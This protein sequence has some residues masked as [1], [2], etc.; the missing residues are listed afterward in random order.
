MLRP[1]R[2]RVLM[3]GALAASLSPTSAH[4]FGEPWKDA[5]ATTTAV[6]VVLVVA[7]GVGAGVS[8]T[9]LAAKQAMAPGRAYDDA[10]VWLAQDGAEPPP[11]LVRVLLAAYR[12]Q[13]GAFENDRLTDREI[14]TRLLAHA[15]R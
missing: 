8:T 6:G 9:F 2:C 14:V 11:L 15:P 1:W 10:A 5:Y 3:L 4:A 7:V 13:L 12:E